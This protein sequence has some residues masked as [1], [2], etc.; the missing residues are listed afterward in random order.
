MTTPTDD[1]FTMSINGPDMTF[2]REID[3][4]II[5]TLMQLAFGGN[6]QSS[7]SAAPLNPARFGA[8]PPVDLDDTTDGSNGA[9]AAK[10]KPGKKAGQKKVNYEVPKDIN[11]APKDQQTLTEYAD[12]KKPK[13]NP[14]RALVAVQ[15]ITH[16]L[17]KA[18]SVGSV[19]AAFKFMNWPAPA[20][21]ANNLQVAGSKHW[22]ET[23]DSN[24]ITV[25]YGGDSQL[26]KMPK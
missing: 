12:L 19:I 25:T 10:K 3:P 15:Y 9:A 11:F 18:A 24:N 20:D 14:E 2:K 8:E 5:P 7:T 16:D 6:G 13:S 21:P 1:K 17:G 4:A 26:D 23:S 22:L